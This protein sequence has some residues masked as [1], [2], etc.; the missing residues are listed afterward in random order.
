MNSRSFN[1]KLDEWMIKYGV[2]EKIGD[3]MI[4]H[5]IPKCTQGN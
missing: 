2:L 4:E 3:E 5:S 1:V